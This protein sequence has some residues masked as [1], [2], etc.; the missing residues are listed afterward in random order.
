VS[1]TIIIQPATVDG[2]PWEMIYGPVYDWYEENMRNW[3][4]EKIENFKDWI[5]S[6]IDGK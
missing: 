5:K 6:K 3:V 1:P 4:K 2:I